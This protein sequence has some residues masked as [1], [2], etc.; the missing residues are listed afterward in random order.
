MSASTSAP[1]FLA[2]K[3]VWQRGEETTM[4]RTLTFCADLDGAAA[5]AVLYVAGASSYIVTVNGRLPGRRTAARRAP[6]PRRQ[7]HRH[8]RR[9]VQLQQLFLP[10]PAVVLL[11]RDSRR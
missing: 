4:N 8:P 1:L 5:N 2:A 6:A 9:R 10:R 11:R 3:P 7:Y